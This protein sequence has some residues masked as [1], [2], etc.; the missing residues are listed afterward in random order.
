MAPG[1][2][3]GGRYEIQSLIGNGG[4]AE[5]YLGVD[6]LL[7]RSVALK[8]PHPSLA[9][10]GKFLARF[11]REARAA[12]ALSHPGIVSILDIGVDP[13]GPYLVLELV[14]GR[15][16]ADALWEE[17]AFPAERVAAIGVAVADALAYAHRQGIVHRDVKP[18]NI[19]LT[20]AGS[21]K[22]LDLG[23]A[24]AASWT[25]LPDT[26]DVR[27]TAEYLAPEQIRGAPTDGR[28]DV[29]SLGIVLYEMLAGRP[30]FT[31]DSPVSTAYMHLE[32]PVP[33]LHVFAPSTP[34]AL[35]AVVMRSLEKDPDRRF[36]DASSVREELLRSRRP[37]PDATIP[38]APR[39][40]TLLLS[41]EEPPPPP[42][43][44]VTGTDPGRPRRRRGAR[45]LAATGLVAVLAVVAT[46]AGMVPIPGWIFGQ[47]P[48]L[49]APANLQAEPACDGSAISTSLELTWSP[50]PDPRVEEYVIDRGQGSRPFEQLARVP[51]GEASFSDSGLSYETLYR[52]RIHAVDRVGRT[53]GT[54]TLDRSGF[55]WTKTWSAP[56]NECWPLEDILFG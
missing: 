38:L 17:G 2:V 1:T 27:G 32:Q 6:R 46:L 41:V 19:M 52:Y 16:L 9:A 21:V 42:P 7:R 54:D 49:A 5:V 33:P 10:S 30:P 37:R 56:F 4:V 11:K 39:P 45:L 12:A 29:Y 18:G 35:Q 25:P 14:R 20:S 53:L 51:A 34:P 55:A 15:T 40:P 31:G 3:L 47:T 23:I 13:E 26:G 50:S 48:A 44:P 43:M 8:V 22:L 36:R 28:A 24:R